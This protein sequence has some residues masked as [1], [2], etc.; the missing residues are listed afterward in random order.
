MSDPMTVEVATVNDKR[1]TPH[2]APER[3]VMPWFGQL[4]SYAKGKSHNMKSIRASI[5]R[6]WGSGGK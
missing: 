2:R 1:V 6:G 5:A 3:S 4:K